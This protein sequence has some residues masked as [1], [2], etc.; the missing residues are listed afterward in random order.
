MAIL[1][2]FGD[3]QHCSSARG[4]ARSGQRLAHWRLPWAVAHRRT[5][6]RYGRECCP[7]PAYRAVVG[8]IFGWGWNVDIPVHGNIPACDRERRT[9]SAA[10]PSIQREPEAAPRT[11]L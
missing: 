4:K 10:R 6:A 9:V 3:A 5:C 2:A 11:T 1:S 7:L 8:V